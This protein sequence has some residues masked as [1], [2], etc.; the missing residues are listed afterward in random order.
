MYLSGSPEESRA[1]PCLRCSSVAVLTCPSIVF[2]WQKLR[3]WAHEG[4]TLW[5]MLRLE[6][7]KSNF[8]EKSLQHDNETRE[9]CC[10]LEKWLQEWEPFP[11][12]QW[13]PW[14]TPAPCDEARCKDPSAGHR[15][16]GGNR[17]RRAVSVWSSDQACLPCSEGNMPWFQKG[18][19]FRLCTV[20]NVQTSLGFALGF[21]QMQY[22]HTSIFPHPKNN[23]WDV[24]GKKFL[25]CDNR[26]MPLVSEYIAN[27]L[28][29]DAFFFTC[30]SEHLILNLSRNWSRSKFNST[31]IGK[32]LMRWVHYASSSV[33]FSLGGVGLATATC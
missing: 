20:L 22:R 5:G 25:F 4:Q 12:T 13:A 15:A 9:K 18:P 14:G 19:P 27:K 3:I 32:C 30:S 2:T 7:G 11:Q 8:Q 26:T 23:P 33:F 28:L 31:F 10:C 29:E 21:L 16:N 6:F 24:K 17:S 1:E